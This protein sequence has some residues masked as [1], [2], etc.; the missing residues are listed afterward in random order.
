[1]KPMLWRYASMR[2]PLALLEL[3][4][5]VLLP[6]LYS[7]LL[8]LSVVGLMLLAARSLDALADPWL[9]RRWDLQSAASLGP[10]RGIAWQALA[11]ASTVFVVGF[12]LLLWWPTLADRYALDPIWSGLVLAIGSVLTFL[13]YSLCTIVYQSWGAALARNNAERSRYA[14][15]REAVGLLGVIVISIFVQ[16][17]SWFEKLVISLMLVLFSMLA[18][19]LFRGL[20]YPR[21]VRSREPEARDFHAI[22][23]WQCHPLRHLFICYMLSAIAAAIP[24]TLILFFVDKVLK[25]PDAAPW[26]LALYFLSA[27]AGLPLWSKLS[28]RLGHSSCWLLAMGVAI[29]AFAFCL[30]LDEADIVAY[31]LVCVVTGLALGGDVAMPWAILARLIQE[32]QAKMPQAMPI[33]GRCIGYWTLVGKLNLALAAGIALPLWQWLGADAQSLSWIY[34]GLPCLLKTLSL[35]WLLRCRRSQAL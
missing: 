23:L 5:Y 25:A 14:L 16:A 15:S 12:L 28:D 7:E 24:A 29:C 4:L 26:F 11:F 27:A 31:G 20:A 17:Q 33:A 9:G 1:M 13:A 30:G 19:A 34:A 8:P 35:L 2:L 32:Q 21:Q 10:L 3:P 22:T 18:L 6:K